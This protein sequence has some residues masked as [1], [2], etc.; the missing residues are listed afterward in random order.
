MFGQFVKYCMSHGAVLTPLETDS[1]ASGHLGLCNPSVLSDGDRTRLIIRNVNFALWCNDDPY[2][3]NSPHGPLCYM[4]RKDDWFLRTRNFLCE[5]S[6]DTLAYKLIDTSE[7]DYEPVFEMAGH[8]DMRLVRWDGKLYGTG[9][10]RDWDERGV[11][12]MHLSELDESTGK[13]L[14][15]V[16][17]KAPGA[18]DSYCEKNWMPVLDMP[19]HYVK[20]CTPLTLVR[21]DP[22][23]GE[24][25]VL[26]EKEVDWNTENIQYDGTDIRGS[27]QVVEWGDYRV[28][29]VHRCRLW[30]NEKKQ[31]SD[32][33]YFTQF[34]VWDR[35][36]NLVRASEPFKFAE[37]GI[38]FTN[39]LAVR[40]GKFLIPFALQDNMC[41]LLSVDE[42]VVADFMFGRSKVFG[43]VLLTGCAILDFFNDTKD[44]QACMAMGNRYLGNGHFASA[45]VCYCR[46]CEYNTFRT[47]DELYECLYWCGM[48]LASIGGMEDY[49]KSLWLRMI[50]T[51]PFRSEGYLMLSRYYGYRGFGIDSHTFA[52][53][54]VEKNSYSF[55]DSVSGELDYAKSLYWTEKY[56]D[57]ETAVRNLLASGRL[58]DRDKASAEDF[59]LMVGED[60][61]NRYRVL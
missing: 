41:F 3:M 40:D 17:I 46:A 18:D 50:D 13:E 32:T 30:Y 1:L 24:S 23:S 26:F 33:G 10:Q 6:D 31:K 22:E 56:R 34:M 38:E 39:G 37:F 36:W 19:F 16:R 12:R 48:S 15:R 11:G 47:N 49:E 2:R 57:A 60:K 5:L 14:S 27:S 52:K 51:D 35:E 25:E 44:S 43:G 58:G 42:A 29:L 54:A 7:H 53:L 55:M 45:F 4:T 21:V 8:E 9:V 28:A 20:W 61:K 59:L